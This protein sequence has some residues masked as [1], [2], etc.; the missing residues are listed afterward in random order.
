MTRTPHRVKHSKNAR[1]FQHNPIKILQLVEDIRFTQK[2]AET[3]IEAFSDYVEQNIAIK[4]DLKDLEMAV[5]ADIRELR[6]QD[7]S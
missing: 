5:K 1:I 7:Q 3:Q 6:A 4:K 2:Q